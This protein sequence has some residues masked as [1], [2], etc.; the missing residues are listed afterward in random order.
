MP[1]TTYA[2]HLPQTTLQ[3]RCHCVLY[4]TACLTPSPH[5]RAYH[6]VMW[7]VH[8]YLTHTHTCT[9]NSAHKTT[10]THH[11]LTPTQ[12]PHHM[13]TRGFPRPL[14]HTHHAPRH[15]HHKRTRGSTCTAYTYQECRHKPRIH[16]EV[17]I[18]NTRHVPSTPQTH[19]H[20]TLHTHV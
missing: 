17:Q 3:H 12:M 13:L 11:R 10:H 9:A 16:H 6:A 4:C 2:P 8:T 15:T 5:T 19:V 14:G 18:L 7:Y 20:H 1:N